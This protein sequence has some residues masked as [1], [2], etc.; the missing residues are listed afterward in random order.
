MIVG[1]DLLHVRFKL[2]TFCC[3]VLYKNGSN[4]DMQKYLNIEMGYALHTLVFELINSD[5]AVTRI[6]AT[7]TGDKV[8][9]APYDEGQSPS[10]F[11]WVQFVCVCMCGVCMYIL[12]E[13]CVC[14]RVVK[15]V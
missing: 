13:A 9:Q 5:K 11:I 4:Y 14:E 8:Y 1:C 10:R 15:A 3:C 2:T 6:M 12:C 7:S